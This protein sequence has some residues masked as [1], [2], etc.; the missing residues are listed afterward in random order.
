MTTTTQATLHL[1]GRAAAAE[2]GVS[3]RTLQRLA[4]R[5]E[6]ERHTIG[7]R[8]LFTIEA[9]H[10]RSD[11][12]QPAG[13]GARQ[14]PSA[15]RRTPPEAR[16]A[17]PPDATAAALVILATRAAAAELE[18]ERLR[19]DL[20]TTRAELATARREWSRSH[21]GWQVARAALDQVTGGASPE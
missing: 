20:E 17:T 7:R 2:L 18:V 6:I 15:P 9:R 12:R 8:S 4:E 1:P 5:G 21:A 3:L 13:E 19:A 11:T 14:T 16:H 10:R